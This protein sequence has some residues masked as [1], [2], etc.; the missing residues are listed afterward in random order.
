MATKNVYLEKVSARL[1]AMNANI[2]KLKA[3]TIEVT[4]EAKI[5]YQTHLES[6]A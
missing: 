2:E 5:E 4:A 1:S 6:V 3:R